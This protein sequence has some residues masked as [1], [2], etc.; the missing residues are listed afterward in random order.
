MK[1]QVELSGE[2]LKVIIQSLDLLSRI[3]MLQLN[4]LFQY[5]PDIPKDK[6]EQYWSEQDN[7]KCSF[8]QL[9]K[10]VF[11]YDSNAYK[12]IRAA[13]EIARA[14][15]DIQQALRHCYAHHEMK[16]VKYHVWHDEPSPN[17]SLGVPDV[18][19]AEEEKD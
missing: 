12:S 16:D 5:L 2:Q 3:N 11:D 6:M 15:W 10:N 4:E 13:D 18:K 9:K 17:S 14:A 7:V 8:N 1:Y 19:A